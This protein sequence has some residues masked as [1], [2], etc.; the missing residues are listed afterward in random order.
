M[1]QKVTIA[2]AP[3]TARMLDDFEDLP[4]V[5]LYLTLLGQI[6]FKQFQSVVDADAF[7]PCNTRQIIVFD[8][9]SSHVIAFRVFDFNLAKR[10][11]I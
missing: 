10:R 9:F 2:C 1:E 7:F 4:F 3:Q 11:V 8:L 6:L 5:S